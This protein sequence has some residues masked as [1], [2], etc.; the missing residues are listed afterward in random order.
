[1][2]VLFIDEAIRA[3]DEDYHEVFQSEAGKRVLMDLYVK[4][5]VGGPSFVTDMHGVVDLNK[6]M[7]VDACK[8]ILRYITLKA[9]WKPQ[10]RAAAERDK[11]KTAETGTSLPK[12][13]NQ[14]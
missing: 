14:I 1:M 4:Y 11:D 10:A 5:N 3:S 6:S 9:K 2:A 8:E 7:F 13:A 12:T